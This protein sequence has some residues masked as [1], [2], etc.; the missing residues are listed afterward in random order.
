MKMLVTS[1]FS[2]YHNVFYPSQ[3]NFFFFQLHLFCCLQMLSIWTSL[4]ILL[5]GKE[6]KEISEVSVHSNLWIFQE[7]LFVVQA[8]SCPFILNSPCRMCQA[9]VPCLGQTKDGSVHHATVGNINEMLTEV[10]KT[11]PAKRRHLT[12]IRHPLNFPIHRSNLL[13]KPHNPVF[14][15]LKSQ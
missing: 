10:F 7:S 9:L 4:N 14:Y 8:S 15:T 5:F 11:H 3:N 12:D 1:T 6:F 13:V 2:F